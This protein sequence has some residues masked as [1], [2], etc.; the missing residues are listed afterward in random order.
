MFYCDAHCG[1]VSCRMT[2]SGLDLPTQFRLCFATDDNNKVADYLTFYSDDYATN[3]SYRPVL[4]ITYS[5]P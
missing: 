2:E 3:T 5:V 4:V 1:M